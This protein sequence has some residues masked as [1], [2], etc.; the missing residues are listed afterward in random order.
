MTPAPTRRIR[1]THPL[2]MDDVY[3][4]RRADVLTLRHRFGTGEILAQ[5]TDEGPH[6]LRLQDVFPEIENTGHGT[7]ARIIRATSSILSFGDDDD[8]PSWT[9]QD[10][11]RARCT[12]TIYANQDPAW[13]TVASLLRQG[14]KLH[15]SWTGSDDTALLSSH[16]L[17]HD[18]LDL[19][20]RRR[21]RRLTFA[22]ANQVSYDA[23]RMVCRY[24]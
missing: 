6:S 18:R 8:E 23:M 13:T 24:G 1:S 7:R 15:L 19:V 9:D 22:V 4:L 10:A 17:H 2:A 21:S 16:Q 20:V 3:A 11:P 14:D 5:L 12:A